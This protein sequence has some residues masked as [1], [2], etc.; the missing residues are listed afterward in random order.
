MIASCLV[1]LCSSN[2]FQNHQPSPRRCT[3]RVLTYAASVACL[4]RSVLCL[5]VLCVQPW[6]DIVSHTEYPGG[7]RVSVDAPAD[8]IPVFQR[9]G[10]TN[11]TTL[12]C[13]Q[14]TSTRAV[15]CMS[16]ACLLHVFCMSSAVCRHHCTAKG[17]GPSQQFCDGT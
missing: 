16:S 6:F 15:F 11:Q 9:G 13:V 3:F 7:Q 4:H 12:T 8:K 2:R 14:F 10:Q 5:V 17:T 1:M